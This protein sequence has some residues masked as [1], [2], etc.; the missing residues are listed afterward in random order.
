MKN[1]ANVLPHFELSYD[2]LYPDPPNLTLQQPQK[3]GKSV[4]PAKQISVSQTKLG[5]I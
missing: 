3:D 5:S 4:K 1:F 2:A